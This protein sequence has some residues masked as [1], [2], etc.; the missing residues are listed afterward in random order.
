MQP[1]KPSAHAQFPG[2]HCP[3]KFECLLQMLTNHMRAVPACTIKGLVAFWVLR[4]SRLCRDFIDM[5][6]IKCFHDLRDS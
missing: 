1:S 4:V 5:Q 2:V 3:P 6:H